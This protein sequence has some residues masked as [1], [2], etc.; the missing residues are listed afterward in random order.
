MKGAHEFRRQLESGDLMRYGWGYGIRG[1]G[2]RRASDEGRQR[3]FCGGQRLA[4]WEA[5]AGSVEQLNSYAEMIGDGGYRC[6]VEAPAF[7]VDLLKSFFAVGVV[8]KEIDALRVARGY[9]PDFCAFATG[10][11]G[12]PYIVGCGR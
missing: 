3:K 4:R 5:K 11:E 2:R 1:A 6:V 7:G 12:E 9:F 10:H 8:F